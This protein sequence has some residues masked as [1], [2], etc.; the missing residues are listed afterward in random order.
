MNFWVLQ[1]DLL[2]EGTDKYILTLLLAYGFT[3][4]NCWLQEKILGYM[5]FS[6]TYVCPW[7]YLSLKDVFNESGENTLDPNTQNYTL[8]SIT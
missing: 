3:K 7:V 4:Q 2:C 6:L 8:Y 1:S 5:D